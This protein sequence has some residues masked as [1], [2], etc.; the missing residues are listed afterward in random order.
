M[1]K[2]SR[3]NII[4]QLLAKKIFDKYYGLGK[5][6]RIEYGYEHREFRG[7][8]WHYLLIGCLNLSL[9]YYYDKIKDN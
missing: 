5:F 3:R 6:F 2:E 9:K 8:N 1:F 7:L 4:N